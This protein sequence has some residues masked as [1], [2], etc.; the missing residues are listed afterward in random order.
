MLCLAVVALALYETG[1][2]LLAPL[3]APTTDDY[4][5]LAAELRPQFQPGQVA[6]PGAGG[7]LIV[8]APQWSEQM[9]RQQLGDLMPLP[10][11][12]RLDAGRFT[13]IWEIA[14]DGAR[15]ADTEGLTVAFEK[16]V[17]PLRLRR[18]DRPAPNAVTFD[19]VSGWQQ[20]TVTRIEKNGQLTPCEKRPDEFGCPNFSFNVMKPQSMEIGT[21]IRRALYAQ[22]I[23]AA[24]MVYEWKDVP[25]GKELAVGAGLHH[26]W[27]RKQ[28]DGT[29]T[30][31][32]LVNGQ[33]LDTFTTTN[34]TGFRVV[35]L[36]TAAAAGKP[37]TVRFEVT[38]TRMSARYF[39]FAAE[40]RGT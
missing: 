11:V 24:T 5:K 1:Q 26:V 27:A 16:K 18:Y 15:H 32:I 3:F 20:A 31:R 29:V 23:D 8:A 7:D 34:R 28:G 37:G 33:L 17:G 6:G 14:R 39:G 13:R 10:M 38:T 2:A 36:A 19:F 4:S 30:M 12:S 40:A 22:P 21:T 9:V 35:R 25:L